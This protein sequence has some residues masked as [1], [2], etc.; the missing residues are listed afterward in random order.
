[1]ASGHAR[2]RRRP[3]VLAMPISLLGPLLN[4]VPLRF[5]QFVI[6]VLLLL[7]RI[8]WLRKAIVRESG[9]IPLHDENAVF[10]S[11]RAVLN[12]D[13]HRRHASLH[14]IAG[15]AA[16]KAVLVEGLEVAFIV[17]AVGVGRGL[18]WPAALGAL[19]ACL[20]ILAVGTAVHKL[21]TPVPEN[22]VKFGVGV[23]MCAFGVFCTGEGLGVDWPGEDVA[24][25]AF[26]VVFLATGFIATS[27]LR[28]TT[29]VM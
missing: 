21:L 6:G 16:L 5:L 17:I 7:F 20:V 10:A 4:L 19:A 1:M 28:R 15:L 8:G 27:V 23:M 11:E 12:E 14:W 18:L 13:L 3:A 2:Y 24:L 25:V 22:A 29:E 26:A 9:I